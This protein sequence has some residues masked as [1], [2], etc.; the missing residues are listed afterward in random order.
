MSSPDARYR[1]SCR[2]GNYGAAAVRAEPQFIPDNRVEVPA[3]RI[4]GS[5]AASWL[6]PM[7]R[8]TLVWSKK[9]LQHIRASSLHRAHAAGIGVV[10]VNTAGGDAKLYARRH[11]W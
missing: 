5:S 1:C 4:K 11:R 7:T 9:R 3:A 10:Q 6:P 2:R 8:I